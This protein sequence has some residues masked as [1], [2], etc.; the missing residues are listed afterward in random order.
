M[1][2]WPSLLYLVSI[3]K[4]QIHRLNFSGFYMHLGESTCVSFCRSGGEKS[5][6]FIAPYL[7]FTKIRFGIASEIPSRW[8]SLTATWASHCRWP[9]GATCTFAAWEGHS[10]RCSWVSLLT[11]LW[12]E[13]ELQFSKDILG[14]CHSCSRSLLVTLSGQG[15]MSWVRHRIWDCPPVDQNH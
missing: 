8:R 6:Q 5:K 3:H 11:P 10:S 13:R 12:S 1:F 9:K 7:G 4:T 14:D 15:R 2:W